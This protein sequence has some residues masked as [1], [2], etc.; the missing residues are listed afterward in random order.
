MWIQAGPH[1]AHLVDGGSSL[2]Q[3][4]PQSFADVGYFHRGELLDEQTILVW[5][6][7]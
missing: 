7:G 1:L 3:F 2:E 5:L 4:L 6:A